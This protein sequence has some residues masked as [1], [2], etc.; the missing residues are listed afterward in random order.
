MFIILF[1]TLWFIS[2]YSKTLISQINALTFSHSN[3]LSHLLP[4]DFN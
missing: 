2:I 4:F 1:M 3:S